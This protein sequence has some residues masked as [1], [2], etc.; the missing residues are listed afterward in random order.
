MT[1]KH[2][3]PFHS[4][5]QLLSVILSQKVMWSYIMKTSLL[6]T[7]LATLVVYSSALVSVPRFHATMLPET[8]ALQARGNEHQLE[9][10]P[11]ILKRIQARA[12]SL[13]KSAITV[14]F[15]S[16][17]FR[18]PQRVLAATAAV[19]RPM[20]AVETKSTKSEDN[21]VGGRVVAVMAATGAG[22]AVAK[23]GIKRKQGNDG[24]ESESSTDVVPAEVQGTEPTLEEK[25]TPNID[26]VVDTKKEKERE[27]I[28]GVLE[29]VKEA[30]QK[31]L[32]RTRAA[33]KT[34]IG[35]KKGERNVLEVFF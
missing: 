14:A 7:L 35:E 17:A 12:K 11:G 23:Y 24:E 16:L 34:A 25:V 31:A 5:I 1:T 10:K 8:K 15:A 27:I 28:A 32:E 18:N 20:S 29:K 9:T 33:L 13:K 2:P 19:V 4:P 21:V 26:V 3:V 30:E 22:A 6:V